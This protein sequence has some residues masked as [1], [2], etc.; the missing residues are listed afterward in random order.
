MAKH[1]AFIQSKSEALFSLK[2][3]SKSSDKVSS[4]S[5]VFANDKTESLIAKIGQNAN[6]LLDL[7]ADM[8]RGSSTGDDEVFMIAKGEVEVEDA[9]LRTPIFAS[10]FGAYFFNP[11]GE[12]QII[13]PYTNDGEAFR[14]YSE[15][16]L[17]NSFPKAFKY[18]HDNKGRLEKRKQ[19]NKWYGYSAP[20]NLALHDLAQIVVPLLANRGLFAYVPEE[21]QGKLCLMA[22]GGFSITIG[23]DCPLNAKYVLGIIN[24]RLIFWKLK[25]LSNLFRGGWITC[26]KQYFGELPIHNINFSDKADKA[27]HDKM[28]QLVEQMMQAKQLSLT[29]RNERDKDFYENKC[30]ALDRQIDRLV[31][32][33]YDLTDDEIALIENA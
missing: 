22:S 7:P 4:Q 31:Y 29:P 25:H 3:E 27:R 32:E 12:W 10:D 2:F 23:D 21:T 26:T 17:R 16:E 13:F 8:S 33:L 15:Q 30:A 11:R 1:F 6:R 9:I 5:W 24:S 28:V 14:L 20:R 18:L 19:F